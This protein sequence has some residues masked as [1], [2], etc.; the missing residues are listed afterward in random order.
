MDFPHM[1]YRDKEIIKYLLVLKDGFSAYNWLILY[2]H[3]D[4]GAATNGL[5]K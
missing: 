1:G 5:A 2:A 4:G 3:V